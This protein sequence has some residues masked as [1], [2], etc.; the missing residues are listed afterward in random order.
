MAQLSCFL[1]FEGMPVSPQA[2]G[3]KSPLNHIASLLDKTHKDNSHLKC[4]DFPD[5][6]QTIASFHA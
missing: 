3:R 4:G 2:A 6:F 1:R 5:T